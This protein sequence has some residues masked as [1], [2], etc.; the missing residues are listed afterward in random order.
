MPSELDRSRARPTS[1]ETVNLSETDDVRG[2][3]AQILGGGSGEVDAT[4][5]CVGFEAHDHGR[6]G[7]Q[8]EQPATRAASSN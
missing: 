4:V 5:D 8:N 2:A 1:R 3:S 6:D 7:A